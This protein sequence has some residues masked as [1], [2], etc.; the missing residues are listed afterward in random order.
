MCFQSCFDLCTIER[1][2]YEATTLIAEMTVQ[3][4]RL[5]RTDSVIWNLLTCYNVVLCTK[6]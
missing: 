5:V 4:M 1:L 6:A 2:H 3:W